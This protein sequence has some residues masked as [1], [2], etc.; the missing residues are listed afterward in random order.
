[1][2]YFVSCFEPGRILAISMETMLPDLEKE[3]VMMR[4][5]H[6]RCHEICDDKVAREIKSH[7]V[8]FFL[9]NLQ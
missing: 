4:K 2:F 8:L 6:K 3:E 9:Q 7:K 1:M 5:G